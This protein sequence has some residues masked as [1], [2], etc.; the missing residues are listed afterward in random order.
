MKPS[1][2][3]HD[4]QIRPIRPCWYMHRWVNA[5]ADSSLSGLARWYA[6]LHVAGCPQCRTALDELR[7][8][9][10]RLRTLGKASA[11]LRPGAITRGRWETLQAELDALDRRPE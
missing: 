8:L 7:A 3:A 11:S 1:K 10:D 5:L 4:P 6:N 9:R 2:T